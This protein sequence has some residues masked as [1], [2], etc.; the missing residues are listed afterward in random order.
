MQQVLFEFSVYTIVHRDKL[1]KAAST[2]GAT[3]FSE[4]K[5]WRNGYDLWSKAKGA[6]AVMPVVFADAMD[7]SRLL[8]WGLLTNIVIEDK[9]TRYSVEHMRRIKG[10]HSPQ[11]LLLK[12]TN[13]A[14]APNF[15]R[16]Y[17]ICQTPSFL[18]LPTVKEPASA[19]REWER[20]TGDLA[21]CLADLSEDEFLV[22]SSKSKDYYVQFA[23]QGQFGMRAEA[24]SNAYIEP[25]NAR[26]STDAYVALRKLGW[27]LPTRV[28]NSGPDPDGSPNFFMDLSS[29]GG[30]GSIAGIAVQTFRRVYHIHHPGQLQYKSFSRAGAQIRFPTLRIKREE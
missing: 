10:R 25:A 22:L 7:C 9:I 24:A 28:P 5:V 26:L 12:S 2:S 30:F 16:P 15:I 29:S 11:E 17:A 3:K 4:A 1:A 13:K 21:L 19:D 23:A 8:Y 6:G 14:I 18:A 27:K 20:F